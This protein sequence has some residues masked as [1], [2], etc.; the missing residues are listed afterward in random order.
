MAQTDMTDR[1]AFV[2]LAAQHEE[3]AGEVAAGWDSILE[4][5][6]FVLGEEVA[7][8]EDEFARFCGVAHCV[9]VGNGTDAV[10]FALRAVGVRAGDEVIVPTNSFVASAMGVL[11][12]GA[13]PVLVDVDPSTLLIQPEQAAERIGPKT[14]A[15]LPVHLFG[16]TAPVEALRALAGARISI[17]EDA[18]QSQGARR[19]GIAAGALGD[20]AATSFYPGKNLGA[21]GDAR[22]GPHRRPGDRRNRQGSEES[23]VLRQVRTPRDRLQ[24][25]ARH[26]AGRRAFVEATSTRSV[27]RGQASRRRSLRDPP[28]RHGTCGATPNALR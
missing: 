10:E 8:F 9:G 22:S 25:E 19:F 3:I 5:A 18:A 6:A 26:V 15:I 4:R 20:A 14:R 11:R 27:E 2:D 7:A 16:Q 24:L 12:A 13:V 28:L 1:I 21:Y 17:V 23:R